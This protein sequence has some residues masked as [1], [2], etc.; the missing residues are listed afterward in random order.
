MKSGVAWLP[1][2]RSH[3]RGGAFISTLINHDRPRTCLLCIQRPGPR[4]CFHVWVNRRHVTH[5]L[6]SMPVCDLKLHSLGQKS[7]I[8]IA[9][10]PIDPD[11]PSFFLLLII[12]LTCFLRA[13]GGICDVSNK[14]QLRH[15]YTGHSMDGNLLNLLGPGFASAL[16][17]TLCRCLCVFRDPQTS[18]PDAQGFCL[19]SFEP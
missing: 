18:Q 1:Q 7:V 14:S 11:F 12:N 6:A 19:D 2:N 17:M 15:F 10:K 9:Q 5:S 4:L 8:A 3:A 13:K 16:L